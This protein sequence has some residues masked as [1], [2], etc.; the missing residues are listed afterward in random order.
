MALETASFDSDEERYFSYWL[1]E[2]K[3]LGYIKAYYRPAPMP[4]SAARQYTT[5]V[6]RKTMPPRM[7][8]RELL[9]AHEYTADFL[10]TWTEKAY[11]IFHEDKNAVVQNRQVPFFSNYN[12]ITATYYSLLEIK[13]SFDQNNMTRA[14][15]LNQKWIL[16]QKGIYVELVK[17]PDFFRKTFT[18]VKYLYTDK[19]RQRRKINFHVVTAGEYLKGGPHGR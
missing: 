9:K 11:G 15:V 16:C 5:S 18:P 7:E 8:N 6:P 17:I 19:T 10:V 12:G 4:L 3:L 2:L 14:F 13:P 1:D